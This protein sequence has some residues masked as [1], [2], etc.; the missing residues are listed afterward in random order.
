L[1]AREGDTV[2]LATPNGPE[3]IEVISITY[4]GR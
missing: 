4:P 1:K 3:P 2:E